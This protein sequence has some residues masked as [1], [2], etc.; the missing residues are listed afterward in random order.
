MCGIWCRGRLDRCEVD[1]EVVEDDEDR[2]R[3]RGPDD[4]GRKTIRLG[5]HGTMTLAASVLH[6]RGEEL[7]RQPIEKG[8]S[9]LCWNGEIWGGGRLKEDATISSVNDGEWLMEALDKCQG[10]E[11]GVHSLLG[12]VQGPFA[13][14]YYAH[15]LQRL[16]YGRDWMGR[17]SL[18]EQWDDERQWTIQSVG[19]V[20]REVST[21]ALFY[22]DLVTGCKCVVP[23]LPP[24]LN[25]AQTEGS[26]WNALARELHRHLL[27]AM[28]IRLNSIPK[29]TFAQTR[30]AILFSGGLDCTVLAKLADS[31]LPL[32][33]P[34]DLLN[35][36][37]ERRG[38]PCETCPDRVTGRRALAEAPASE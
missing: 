27:H 31:C 10:S 36:A 14:V 25:M 32:N 9:V 17:R 20:G 22:V 21:D 28:E 35:V 29:S 1:D 12:E 30:L 2:M 5:A 37:F 4:Y 3:A 38:A 26:D 13:F 18:L 24:L 19:G 6:L 33:E 16:Y 23:R 34:I 15:G 7:T 8:E 11:S